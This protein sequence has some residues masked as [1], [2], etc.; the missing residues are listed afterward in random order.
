MATK[1]LLVIGFGKMAKAV[2]GDVPSAMPYDVT[3]VKPRPLKIAGAKWPR[4]KTIADLPKNYT[5][6]LVLFAVKPD[7]MDALLPQVAKRFGQSPLYVSMIAA[8][9]MAYY[10]KALGVK[11]KVLRAMPNILMQVGAGLTL[12]YASTHCRESDIKKGSELFVK[13]SS[14]LRCGSERE[15]DQMVVLTSC[16]PGFLFRFG[17]LLAKALQQ[18]LPKGSG[19]TE[20]QVKEIAAGLLKGVGLY[21]EHCPELPFEEMASQVATKGGLTEA[22]LKAM[23]RDG[24]AITQAL[25]KA[26]KA[27]NARGIKIAAK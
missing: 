4:Y 26:V 11:A 24:K 6:D 13:R 17:D 5:P 25:V 8:R 19:L 22:G 14:I 23:Q 18:S 20:V 9:R 3:V 27:A 12:V 16:M 10:A 7:V 21:A 2:F 1:K 15:F